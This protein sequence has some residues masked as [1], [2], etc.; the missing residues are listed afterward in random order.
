MA[1]PKRCSLCHSIGEGFAVQPNGGPVDIQ[2]IEKGRRPATLADYVNLQKLC[3]AS[4]IIEM[5]EM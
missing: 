3:Q 5:V 1:N 4:D 2:D